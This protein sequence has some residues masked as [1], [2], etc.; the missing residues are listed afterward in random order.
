ML[1]KRVVVVCNF[2]AALAV[3][4]PVDLAWGG[5]L[6]TSEAIEGRWNLAQVAV[7]APKELLLGKVQHADVSVSLERPVHVLEILAH[8]E[9]AGI[10]LPLARKWRFVRVQAGRPAEFKVPYQLTKKFQSGK[11]HFEIRMQEAPASR[12]EA[13]QSATLRLSR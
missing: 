2:A 6:P 7:K 11:I 4:M 5:R 12:L 10:G 13:R 3:A 8:S 9:G 1:T